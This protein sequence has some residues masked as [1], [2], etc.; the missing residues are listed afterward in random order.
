[1][2]CLRVAWFWLGPEPG[3]G[4]RGDEPPELHHPQSERGRG[5]M[6]QPPNPLIPKLGK[7]NEEPVETGG[8]INCWV[9]DEQM[10]G[11]EFLQ[12]GPK[13]PYPIHL[14]ELVTLIVPLT[15]GGAGEIKKPQHRP[16][17]YN[18]PFFFSFFKKKCLIFIFWNDSWFFSLSRGI[19]V[20]IFGVLRLTVLHRLLSGLNIVLPPRSLESQSFSSI[21]A[22]STTPL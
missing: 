5:T 16:K 14:R 4:H 17:K 9:G 21:Q 15:L 13:S 12:Q 6:L 20:M 19:R 3:N 2:I 18:S 1:M 8:R 22:T 11:W 7:G 10:W